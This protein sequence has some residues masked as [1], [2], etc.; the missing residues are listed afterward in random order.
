MANLGPGQSF[1][2]GGHNRHFKRKY[3]PLPQD[4]PNLPRNI[5]LGV[6]YKL[7]LLWGEEEE[8][9]NQKFLVF[10]KAYLGLIGERECF[11]CVKIVAMLFMDDP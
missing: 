4:L 8:H 6:I 5:N 10:F 3:L 1:Y 2:P 11:E 9:K 7:H